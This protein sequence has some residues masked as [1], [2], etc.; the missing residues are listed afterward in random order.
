MSSEKRP[1][2]M[3]NRDSDELRL[4]LRGRCITIPRLV[5][6]QCK[7]SKLAEDFSSL[8]LLQKDAFGEIPLDFSPDIFEHLV[9]HL[10]RRFTEPSTLP[11]PPLSNPTLDDEFVDL[12]RYYGMLEW[13]HRQSPVKFQLRIGQY[14]YSV[15][16]P[17]PPDMGQD[18]HEMR[19][20][21]ITIPRGWK[22]LGTS[23]DGFEKAISKLTAKGWGTSLLLAS[24]EDYGFAGYRTPLSR[25]GLAGSRLNPEEV[26][27][28]WFDTVSEDRRSLKFASGSYRLVVRS[29]ARTST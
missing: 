21:T 25:S 10:K 9:D 11:P 5:L 12:L 16:P 26:T 19:G 7:E 20:H 8:E 17:Q 29:R 24:D 27:A 28:N 2:A 4:N 1:E 18:L 13:V 6:T 3:R 23:D 14:D 15:L 22:I